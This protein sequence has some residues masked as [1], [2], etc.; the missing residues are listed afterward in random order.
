[1][2]THH[3]G[4]IDMAEA[5]QANGSYEPAKTMAANVVRTQT[6]EINKMAELLKS[7]P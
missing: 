7:I 4:A 2:T 3:Q 1:M 5:E 6:D